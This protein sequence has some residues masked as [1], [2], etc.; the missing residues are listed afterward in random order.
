MSDSSQPIVVGTCFATTKELRQAVGAHFASFQR[1]FVS[2]RNGG[3]HQKIY[4]CAGNT[5]GCPA[6]VRAYK[7]STGEWRANKINNQH[8]PCAGGSATGKSSGL[9][10][11]ARQALNDNIDLQGIG[12]KRKIERDT[13]IKVSHRTATRMKNNA[14][15]AS[16]SEKDKSYQLLPPF[17][18]ELEEKCPGTVAVVEVR[19]HTG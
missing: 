11:I 4:K 18:A 5:A 13:G 8:N 10:A 7:Q 14:K 2:S 16:T 12:L 6:E 9:S 1:S 15:A 17:C 3:G 19:L